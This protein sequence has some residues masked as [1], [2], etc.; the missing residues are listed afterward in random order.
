MRY[1]IWKYA[2]MLFCRFFV[3]TWNNCADNE[4]PSTVDDLW[5]NDIV[6][7]RHKTKLCLLLML[8]F[9]LLDEIINDLL[10]CQGKSQHIICL[11]LYL[12][13]KVKTK[14]TLVFDISGCIAAIQNT[15]WIWYYFHYFH[16]LLKELSLWQ[17]KRNLRFFEE[18]NYAYIIA[19]QF[20]NPKTLH[21][22]I[23][24]KSW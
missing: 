3:V 10:Y 19:Q 23:V 1:T 16:A 2:K 21:N 5:G 6:W 12:H 15:L 20:N 8:L 9:Y 17:K 14:I 18:K 11:F 13:H 7:C 24:L 4:L 22:F